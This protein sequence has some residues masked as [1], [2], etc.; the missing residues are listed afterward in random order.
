MKNILILTTFVAL[1][2]VSVYSAFAGEPYKGSSSP[3][4]ELIAKRCANE[5]I[6]KNYLGKIK[7]SNDAYIFTTPGPRWSR[8]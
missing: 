8:R 2:F 7:E 3:S 5:N 6:V 4:L 1:T